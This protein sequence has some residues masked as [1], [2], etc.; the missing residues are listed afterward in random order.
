MSIN[1]Q[2]DEI[3][4]FK[5][6]SKFRRKYKD[7]DNQQKI[8]LQEFK[9]IWKLNG[10]GE[11]KL[12]SILLWV[13]GVLIIIVI[14]Q[15]VQKSNKNDVA[16][17]PIQ[18]VEKS[19]EEI[20]PINT[21]EPIKEFEPIKAIEPLKPMQLPMTS[22]LATSYDTELATCPF[23]II[24]D[25]KNYYVKLCNVEN[26]D[27]TV[28]IFFIRAREKLKTKVPAGYYKLKYGA[29]SDWYGEKELFGALSQYGESDSLLFEESGYLSQGHTVS[30]FKSALG[31]F[32]TDRI[33]RDA[34]LQN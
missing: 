8:K 13:L 17:N 7:F 33:G 24:A 18:T 26:N 12:P 21:V 27:Q 15:Y 29:G 23:T 16:L 28:A 31:N 1:Q 19:T 22:I 11:S 10:S 20:E 14:F 4:A 3:Q 5:E 6:A 30:F 25:N 34:V 2:N 9:Q 32:H